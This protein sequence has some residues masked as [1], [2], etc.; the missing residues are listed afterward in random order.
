MQ[1]TRIPRPHWGR[2]FTELYGLA[3]AVL[4]ADVPSQSAALC[5]PD[6]QLQQQLAL[7]GPVHDGCVPECEALEAT[8]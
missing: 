4:I 5:S 6:P 3:R 7:S 2:Q 8:L 1:K